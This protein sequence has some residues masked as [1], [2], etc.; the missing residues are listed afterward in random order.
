MLI[1]FQPAIRAT[2]VGRNELGLTPS[3]PMPVAIDNHRELARAVLAGDEDRA[4]ESSRR[5][6][7]VVR[8]EL[9][10]QERAEAGGPGD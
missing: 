2:L 3:D 6:V 1:A 9:A 4:E 8:S 10:L 7:R 5:I